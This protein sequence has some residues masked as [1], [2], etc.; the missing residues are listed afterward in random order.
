MSALNELTTAQWAKKWADKNGLDIKYAKE[1]LNRIDNLIIRD[2]WY[3]D[4]A[5]AFVLA[6]YPLNPPETILEK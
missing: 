6:S 5:E 4:E 1:A 3:T 2:G